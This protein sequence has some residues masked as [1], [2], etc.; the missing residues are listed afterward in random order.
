MK[1][2]KESDKFELTVKKISYTISILA[3]VVITIPLIMG[4]Y[5]RYVLGS[6]IV[7]LMFFAPIAYIKY[8][9]KQLKT[10]ISGFNFFLL[11]LIFY[12]LFFSISPNLMTK[13][14]EMPTTIKVYRTATSQI[15]TVDFKYYVK[16]VIT[17]EV[18]PS[19]NKNSLKA[20]AMVIKTYG[21]YWTI[22][23]KY[24]GQGYDVKDTFADQ[25][26]VPDSQDPV[27]DQAVDDIWNYM[28][29]MNGD[30]FEPEYDSGTEGR[31]EPLYSGRLS[32]WGSKFLADQGN[33]W[34]YILH[35]YYDPS[36]TINII[37]CT[38]QSLTAISI[39][40]PVFKVKSII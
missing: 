33:D 36:G 39:F 9:K 3:V 32:Q 35:Y 31:T 16:N 37:Y 10:I 28:M 6:L 12:I 38:N 2:I 13:N 25:V 8:S 14:F 1:I 4:R 24:P 26:Y 21:W 40:F 15:D 20:M 23:Q 34:Q 7:I 30:I 18:S 29:T 17:N 5:N 11:L 27:S 19:W 22:H